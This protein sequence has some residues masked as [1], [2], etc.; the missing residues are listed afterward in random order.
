MGPRW[1]VGH[2]DCDASHY[3]S[4]A[5]S[6]KTISINKAGVSVPDSSPF[7]VGGLVPFIWYSFRLRPFNQAGD[8]SISDTILV[9]TLQGVP[10]PPV[11]MNLSPMSPYGFIDVTW[12]PPLTPNGVIMH[13]VITYNINTTRT[14]STF[15]R[16]K[17]YGD[18]DYVVGLS[19]C[20]RPDTAFAC[21]TATFQ[22]LRTPISAP[23][24]PRL[25][26]VLRSGPTKVKVR[27]DPPK[28]PNGPIQDYVIK[29]WST[30]PSYPFFENATVDVV[31]VDQREDEVA[32]E[33]GEDVQEEKAFEIEIFARTVNEEG[34]ELEGES[35]TEGIVMCGAPQHVSAMTLILPLSIIVLISSLILAGLIYWRWFRR[36]HKLDIYFSDI[37]NIRKRNKRFQ[38]LRIPRPVAQESEVFDVIRTRPSFERTEVEPNE[39][40]KH[41]HQLAVIDDHRKYTGENVPRAMGYLSKDDSCS[42]STKCLE[43]SRRDLCYDN[44]DDDVDENDNRL[45]TSGS[46]GY[47]SLDGLFN[48]NSLYRKSSISDVESLCKEVVYSQVLVTPGIPKNSRITRSLPSVTEQTLTTSPSCYH[49][50]KDVFKDSRRDI[51]NGEAPDKILNIVYL[52]RTNNLKNAPFKRSHDEPIYYMLARGE[53]E[54]DT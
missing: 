30:S 32:I 40:E 46:S 28:H 10:S 51:R 15:I 37:V 54:C 3:Q 47:L 53:G 2:T 4:P 41:F 45:Y 44:G 39:V 19:A 29:V 22:R 12:S 5:G 48:S 13:Y 50:S 34:V 52:Q 25:Q 49:G 35:D 16:L 42:V 27:W 26:D 17:V 21:S 38:H 36:S 20:T 43:Y 6:E 7:R 8:G 14:N 1:F 33:C 9:R 31:D 18:T 24:S 11:D 23:S